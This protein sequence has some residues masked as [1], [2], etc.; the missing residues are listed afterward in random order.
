MQSVRK[1]TK[2]CSNWQGCVSGIIAKNQITG[3]SG[4]KFG[5]LYNSKI[6]CLT[7]L[8]L[9]TRILK[10]SDLWFFIGVPDNSGIDPRDKEMKVFYLLLRRDHWLFWSNEDEAIDWVFI[11][12]L[13]QYLQEIRLNEARLLLENGT[14]DTIAAVAAK[15]GYKNARSFSRNFK[16]PFGKL[17]ADFA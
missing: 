11:K 13:I 17:P 2:A 8:R 1:E 7:C 15:V 12:K 3:G 10:R 4:F 9:L 5:L 16:N 6:S 14:P